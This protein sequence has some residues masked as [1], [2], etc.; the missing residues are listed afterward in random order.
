MTRPPR[1]FSVGW[2]MRA[3]LARLRPPTLV[4]LLD[5]AHEPSGPRVARLARGF[6]PLR[7]RGGLRL[8]RSVVPQPHGHVDRRLTPSGLAL[9]QKTTKDTGRARG[10]RELAEA[11]ARN[12]A[13]R[14][15]R[16]SASSIAF[17]IK[18]PGAPVQS[19]RQDARAHGT[20]ELGEG[21]RRIRFAFPE[22]PRTGRRVASLRAVH[23]AYGANVVYARD[24]SRG[25]AR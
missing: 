9:Y 7:R 17:A 18:R 1:R 21:A 25:R 3:A 20:V 2:R 16:S 23:K 5:D 13:K 10:G 11:Q 24:R 8:A 19:R 15:P 14:G 22:P 12:Q 6:L 4:A